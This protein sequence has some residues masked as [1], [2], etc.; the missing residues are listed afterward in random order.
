[1]EKVK[2]KKQFGQNFLKDES[3]LQ[4]IIQSIPKISTNIVEIGPGLGDLT[5]WLLKSGFCVRAYEIDNELI[6]KLQNKFQKELKDGNFSLINTDA[7]EIWKKDGSLSKKPYFIVANL[8]YYVATKMILNALADSLCL[9]VVA[10]VQKEVAIKFA[11]KGGE[12][13]FSALGVLANLN[14]RCDLLFDVDRHC[15][16]PIP[17]VLSSVISIQKNDSCIFDDMSEYENFK[18]FLKICFIAP[19][20]FLFK[21]LS[22]KFDK[23]KLKLIFEKLNLLPNIRPH[24]SSVA[25]YLDIY[26][27]IRKDN[28]RKQRGQSCN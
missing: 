8:P 9:G 1:M 24:E 15:F 18:D 19:R 5:F 6:E 28:E 17:K 7:N 2:A 4:K 25:L 3:V 22:T 26:K 13:E 21:N 12:K 20:K 23:E 10:M 11:C 16:N 14:A 27:L